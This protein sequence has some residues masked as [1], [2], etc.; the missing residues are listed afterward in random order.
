MRYAIFGLVICAALIGCDA[1]VS[2]TEI[3]PGISRI[4]VLDGDTL[5]VDGEVVRL[6]DVDAPELAPN[7]A[8]WAEAA[9]AGHAKSAVET[10]LHEPGRSWRVTQPRGRDPNGHLIAS[11]TRNDGEDLADLLVVYGYAARSA[12]W[13]WCG[14]ASDLRAREGPNLWYP[15]DERIDERAND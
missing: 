3:S 13:D 11:L 4:E 10:Y 1:P 6:A 5:V 14:E 7:A 12:E 8:C 15:S 9:L 2:I